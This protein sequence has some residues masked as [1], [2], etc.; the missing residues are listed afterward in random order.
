MGKILGLTAL[1]CLGMAQHAAA[2][3]VLANPTFATDLSGWTVA[4]SAGFGTT[5]FDGALDANSNPASGSAETVAQFTG[6]GETG[7]FL[8]QCYETPTPGATYSY[9]GSV[10]IPGNQ[11]TSGSGIVLVSFFNQPGCSAG[12]LSSSNQLTSTVGAW[13]LLTGSVV[14]PPGTQSIWFTFQT[15]KTQAG[16]NFQVNYDNAELDG[17]SPTTVSVPTLSFH[18]TLLLAA[19][20]CAA[21]AVY[22]RRRRARRP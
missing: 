11:P 18:G 4:N 2:V 7:V 8:Q 1:A 12:F 22:A 5:T 15:S 16:G 9:S 10:F 3:N 19:L 13:T 20:L 17:P 6:A 21:A 14:A